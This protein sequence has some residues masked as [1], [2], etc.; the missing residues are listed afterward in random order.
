MN[1]PADI[2]LNKCPHIYL[3]ILLKINFYCLTLFNP[4]SI[5]VDASQSG[6]YVDNGH[7]QTIMHRTLD[8]EEKVAASY[9]ILEFLGL[10]ER[11][12]RKHAHLSLR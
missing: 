6:I 10:P 7:D 4:S 12:R 2:S 3:L 9:E 11:P 5:F 8:E 1:L